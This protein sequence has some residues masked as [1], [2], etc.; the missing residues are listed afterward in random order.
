MNEYADKLSMYANLF[1]ETAVND[2][3]KLGSGD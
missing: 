1:R 3:V 2:F